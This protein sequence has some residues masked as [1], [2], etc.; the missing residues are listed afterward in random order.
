MTTA[1][2]LCYSASQRGVRMGTA[3]R[4]IELL[5]LV[6]SDKAWPEFWDLVL[7]SRL[8]ESIGGSD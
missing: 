8:W 1:K 7:A 2:A 6:F 4:V 5:G 3:A